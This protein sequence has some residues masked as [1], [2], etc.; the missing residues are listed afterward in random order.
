MESFPRLYDQRFNTLT[1]RDDV[2]HDVKV[3]CIVSRVV[4]VVQQLY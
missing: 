4:E 3:S 1:S 2:I